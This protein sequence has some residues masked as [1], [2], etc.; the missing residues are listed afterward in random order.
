MAKI[1]YNACFGGFCL[2]AAAIE[3]YSEIQGVKLSKW[4]DERD[5]PRND[6]ALVQVVEELGERAGASYSRLRIKELPD[7]T[8]YRIDEYDGNES[9]MTMNDYEWSVA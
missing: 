4:F 1:V 3:R 7:G 6:P 5:I 8:L 2:S 9:V